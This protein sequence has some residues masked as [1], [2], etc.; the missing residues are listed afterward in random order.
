[1]LGDDGIRNGLHKGT[2]LTA[3]GTSRENC[4]IVCLQ[5]EML[6]ICFYTTIHIYTR[7]T[8]N[9]KAA[10]VVQMIGLFNLHDIERK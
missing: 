10:S 3:Q 8:P 6:C 4:K 5:A 2:R 1:M 9:N 7:L